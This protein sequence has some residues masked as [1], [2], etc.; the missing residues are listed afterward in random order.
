VH[1]RDPLWEAPGMPSYVSGLSVDSR[2]LLMTTVLDAEPE[3]RESFP[4][5]SPWPCVGALATSVLFIGS[6]FTPW[7]VVWGSVPVGVALTF[8]FWPRKG[9]TARHLALEQLP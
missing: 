4:E 7:A 6:I 9:P 1:G 2:E 5:P 3:S 8:W